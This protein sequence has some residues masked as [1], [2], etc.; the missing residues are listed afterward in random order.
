MKYLSK[1]AIALT[2][3]GLSLSVS[4]QVFVTPWIG[5]TVG[6]SVE[7]QEGEEFDLEAA[8][9]VALSIETTVDNGRVGFF[10]ARQSSDVETIDSDLDI[11]YLHFQSSLAFPFSERASSYLGVGIGGSYIDADWVDDEWG[12]SASIMGGVEYRLSDSLSLNTQLRWLGTAVDNDTRG[13]CNLPTTHSDGC[14]IQFKTSWM[15]QF[16]ANAG[17]TWRF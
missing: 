2:F 1:A 8:A 16:S 10:Y 7:N 5:Y 12:F 14:I 9:N 15:N 17:V 4:A 6:G 13:V 3:C 11:H